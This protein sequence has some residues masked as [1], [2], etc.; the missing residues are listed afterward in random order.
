MLENF[1]LLLKIAKNVKFSFQSKIYDRQNFRRTWY[2]GEQFS[3][4]TFLNIKFVFLACEFWD[5]MC[6]GGGICICSE[7]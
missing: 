6:E 4:L 7:V 2:L 5:V 1:P 3:K